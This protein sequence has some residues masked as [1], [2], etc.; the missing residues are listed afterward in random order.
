MLQILD[1]RRAL[2]DKVLFDSLF[3]SVRPGECAA[4]VG[5]NGAGKSTLLRCVIGD[6]ILDAGTVRVDE[7]VP[8]DTSPHFRSAVAFDLGDDATFFD[9]TVAEHLRLVLRL[10][11]CAERSATVDWIL[12][13]AGLAEVADR[14]PHTLSTG[15]RQRFSLAVVFMRSARLIVL[16]EPE[17]GL[18]VDGR[19]WLIGKMAESRA[20]IL[21]AT[22][23]AEIQKSADIVVRIGER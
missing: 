3:L 7:R 19:G 4:V 2:G 8:D 15:Q 10:H 23:S 17:Q 18:D 16:D 1:A 21:V 11:R 14:Y 5:P 22:H 6:E 12:A 20:A 13:D 9:L